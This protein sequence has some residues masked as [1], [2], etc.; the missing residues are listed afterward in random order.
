M[1]KISEI[2]TLNKGEI[3]SYQI[4]SPTK[5]DKDLFKAIFDFHEDY[6]A[7]KLIS[8]I[9]IFHEML[10]LVAE[11]HSILYANA[12]A[13]KKMNLVD[14]H[15]H[16]I[17]EVVKL[18][19]KQIQGVFKEEVKEDKFLRFESKL[20]NHSEVPINCE[21]SLFNL[22]SGSNISF[23]I[24]QDISN[25]KRIESSLENTDRKYKNILHET[26]DAVLILK[27]DFSIKEINAAGLNLLGIENLEL[28]VKNFLEFITEEEAKL[29]RLTG[30]QLGKLNNHA[31]KISQKNQNDSIQVLLNFRNILESNEFIVFMKD[32]SG[33]LLLHQIMLRT[34]VQTQEKERERFSR[35]IHDDLGQ[36]LAAL[37]FNLSA[38]RSYVPDEQ[39]KELLIES[40]NILIDTLASVRSIC[41]DL[42]PKSLEKNGLIETI[43]E[44]IRTM[45]A[46]NHVTIELLVE[47]DFPVLSD[48]MNV[49][50]YRII[51]EFINNSIRHGRSFNIKI[52]F[53]MLQN[54]VLMYLSDDG[55]GFDMSE[56]NRKK[57][58]G[59]EN[60]ESRAKAY[61]GIAKFSSKL[62]LGTSCE[63]RM[64]INSEL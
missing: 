35:D 49:A 64:P 50:L 43:R 10:L 47:N 8:L 40:E 27:N 17:E 48:E 44:L 19:N 24:I 39:A 36:Q 62:G 18:D 31:L 23:W 42:M 58:N 34:V 14:F 25:Y 51:Q 46:M 4:P 52:V 15:H 9:D 63:I 1:K 41:F 57:G 54:F 20:V 60:I 22:T 30:K 5:R 2:E 28:N 7:E 21:V 53:K 3:Q 37:K 45:E 12:E 61:N 16:K 6:R 56:V 55:K 32:V 26:S 29:I 59:M 13:I 11:D 38:L 33:E